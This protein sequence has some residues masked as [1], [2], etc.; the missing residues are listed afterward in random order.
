MA[1]GL[2]SSERLRASGQPGQTVYFAWLHQSTCTMLHVVVEVG[3]RDL[4][5]PMNAPTPEDDLGAPALD[6]QS[7]PQALVMQR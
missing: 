7:E 4:I 1:Q 2:P 3:L 6:P 5:M